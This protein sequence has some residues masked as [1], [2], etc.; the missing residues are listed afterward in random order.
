MLRKGIW[1]L[2]IVL[3]FAVAAAAQMPE[4]YL[5]VFIV[6]VKPDKHAEFNAL[7]QKMADANRKAGDRWLAY[8][9]TYGEGDMVTFASARGSY[10]DI[11]KAS[12][13]F[14]E[15]IAKALG[16]AG[17]QKLFADLG[18]CTVSS[19]GELRRRRWDL[20][21]RVP[22]DPA[23]RAKQVGEARWLRM[24]TV[25]VRPGRTLEYEAWLKRIKAAVEKAPGTLS[26]RVSQGAVGQAGGVYYVTWL[27]KSLAD[28]DGGPSL[29]QML[30]EGDFEKFQK[31][32][33][34]TVI[35]TDSTI[36]SFA[37]KLSNPPDDIA[38]AA[39]DFWRPKAMAK[40][41]AAAGAEAKPNAPAKPKQ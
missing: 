16:P 37:P 4:E 6:K 22:D 14:N 35:S 17:A 28:F 3:C 39:P 30:G 19:R 38:A 41:K 23:A 10:A 11:E 32:L 31:A 2:A 36:G 33:A 20:S 7:I 29:M 13:A 27:A 8:E 15:A 5:D 34:E 26:A 25:R 21:T 9:S 40:P 12:A 24:V 1:A 18:N